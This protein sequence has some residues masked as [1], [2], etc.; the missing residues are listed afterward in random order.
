MKQP[1]PMVIPMLEQELLLLDN[2][3]PCGKIILNE[4][5]AVIP[6]SEAHYLISF[7]DKDADLEAGGAWWLTNVILHDSGFIC[8]LTGSKTFALVAPQFPN[9]S[10]KRR[11]E[12]E[13]LEFELMGVLDEGDSET[14]YASDIFS[15]TLPFEDWEL[16]NHS[17]NALKKVAKR[18]YDTAEL[19]LDTD[20][21]KGWIRAS[22]K[23]DDL[24]RALEVEAANPHK[25]I[26]AIRDAKKE[27]PRPKPMQNF[28]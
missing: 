22:K 23:L 15:F 9:L 16:G 11:L 19:I 2:G 17:V 21:K 5:N 14:G 24:Y 20:A 8:R 12:V 7:N 4:K 28:F 3:D 13:Q 10:E 1:Y 25:L 27:P 26:R 18:I 6:R